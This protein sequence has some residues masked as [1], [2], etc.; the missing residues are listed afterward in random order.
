MAIQLNSEQEKAVMHNGGVLLNAGA[1]SGKTRVII[2]H[3][4]YLIEKKY[5]ALFEAGN[6]DILG[7][8]KSYL[9]KIV[10]MTFT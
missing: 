6:T 7:Q 9:S 4:A 8:L 2:E 10:V 1:G 5:D 3:L